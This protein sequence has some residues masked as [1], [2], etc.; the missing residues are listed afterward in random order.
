MKMKS[1]WPYL[2]VYNMF[3]LQKKSFLN[4]ALSCKEDRT[5][6]IAWPLSVKVITNV[7]DVACGPPG[8]AWITW[9]QGRVCE[10]CSISHLV[11]V[12]GILLTWVALVKKKQQRNDKLLSFGWCQMRS[13]TWLLAIC[14]WIMM[15]V[16]RAAW[17][18]CGQTRH[19]LASGYVLSYLGHSQYL[20]ISMELVVSGNRQA[21]FNE[22]FE[23]LSGVHYN[24]TSFKAL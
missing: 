16:V 2:L 17:S 22:A 12:E 23:Y 3:Y 15:I 1:Y 20:T 8:S 6:G 19:G 9:G 24:S 14:V 11:S 10:P 7:T 4:Y 18:G 5:L 21:Y 13:H